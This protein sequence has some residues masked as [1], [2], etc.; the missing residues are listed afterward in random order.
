MTEMIKTK[1]NGEFEIFLP[2][3]TMKDNM[4]EIVKFYMD[5]Q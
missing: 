1:I 3:H 2:E 4:E 5:N